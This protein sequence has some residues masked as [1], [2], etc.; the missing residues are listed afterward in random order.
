MFYTQIANTMNAIFIESNITVVQSVSYT[1]ETSADTLFVST[2]DI[3][4][5]LKKVDVMCED[6]H[7][8]YRMTRLTYMYYLLTRTLQE[9]FCAR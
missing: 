1:E 3:N 5:L 4:L 6:I 7:S 8:L 2:S 9:V